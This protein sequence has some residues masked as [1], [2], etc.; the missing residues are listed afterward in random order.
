MVGK[1]LR[2][3]LLL[4]DAFLSLTAIAGGVGLLSEINAPPVEALAGSP[5]RDYTVPG[6]A[7]LVIV[8][9]EI[10]EILAIGSTPG[11]A[12]TLQIFYLTLG[13]LILALA[14]AQGLRRQRDPVG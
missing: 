14:L 6:L 10:V 8:I 1:I 4:L 2:I 13:G 12:R 3:V 9:F 11:V 5:F 7:L